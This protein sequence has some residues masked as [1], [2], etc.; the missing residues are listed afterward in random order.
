M[1]EEERKKAEA[2]KK[3][4]LKKGRLKWPK[5]LYGSKHHIAPKDAMW[6]DA[7]EEAKRKKMGF[8]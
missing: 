4:G 3:K 7:Q 5:H 1:T 8:K 2:K 6:L